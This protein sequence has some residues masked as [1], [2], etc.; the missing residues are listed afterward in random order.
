MIYAF[1][2]FVLDGPRMELRQGSE[3]IHLEPK[4]FT[5]LKMLLEHSDRVV[6]KDEIFDEVWPG[7]FVTEA[8]LS[9]AVKHIRKALGDD[10]EAQAYIRTI[11]GKGFRFV[12]ALSKAAGRP[13]T[14]PVPEQ[15]SVVN[16]AGPP[17][18]AVLPFTL[19]GKD[20]SETAIAD[21]LPIEIIAALSRLRSIKVIARGSSF[22]LDLKTH[23]LGDIHARLGVT[24]VVAGSVE[25]A[26]RQL[27]I[28]VDVTDTR[29]AQVLWSET[30]LASI[31][32]IFTVREQI[33]SA[34][35]TAADQ[36]IPQNEA[37]RMAS[38][39]TEKL[40]AWGLYHLGLRHLYRFN[41]PDNA[42]A[43]Q[44]FENALQIDPS[45]ARAIAGLSYTEF[46]NFN[47]GFGSEREAH[48]QNALRHAEASV[49]SDPHDPFCNLVLG[50]AHWIH[51]DIDG[52]RAWTDRAVTL[53]PNYAFGHYNSGKFAAIACQSTL[54]DAHVQS[55]LALSPIDPHLQSMLSARA[56][57]A[58]MSDDAQ[59]A[60]RFAEQ[61]LRAPN[62][63]LYVCVIAAAIFAHFDQPHRIEE[64]QRRIA[65]LGSHFGRDHFEMLFKPT[66]PS[67]AKHLAAAFDQLG[68]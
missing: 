59:Q 5:L 20:L 41:A 9:G 36:R 32:D 1:D 64:V 66:D 17:I 18:I 34:V 61:S 48:L 4:H 27:R 67:K 14:G 50:R 6:T 40:D 39:P 24:Y 44:Y 23:G 54:A 21:A 42:K 22:R 37:T 3:V 29:D 43:A 13:A 28:S 7:V 15:Q 10:G 68:F 58:F 16:D 2:A 65:R 56:F 45:F 57:A 12:G 49:D 11:R 26:G 38:V 30:Y 55:A 31:D 8:S 47:L 62:A 46:E 33:V 63:H 25:V 19:L 53:N 35:I 52:A 51:E 60:I